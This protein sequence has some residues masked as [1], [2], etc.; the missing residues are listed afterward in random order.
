MD[1]EIETMASTEKGS[2]LPKLPN[3]PWLAPVVLATILLM[4]A[5]LALAYCLQNADAQV[6][7]NGEQLQ[8]LL[9]GTIGLLIGGAALAL[10]LV[11][12][13]LAMT[14][15]SLLVVIVMALVA[16]VLLLALA[17]IIL[18]F[19]LLALLVV[20]LSKR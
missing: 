12:A 1:K 13:V 17:P 2:D 3:R 18:P 20:W 16:V 8:G 9:G 14:G 15:A 5:T 10:G 19:A 11:I 6:V 4:L 7:L